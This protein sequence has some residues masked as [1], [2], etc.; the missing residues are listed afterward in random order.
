MQL[1]GRQWE[2]AGV[3]RFLNSVLN[4]RLIHQREHLFRLRF[5]GGKKASPEASGGKDRL[6]NL[7]YHR[8]SILPG[9]AP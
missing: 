1:V 6:T 3:D 9:S 4:Q 8:Y 7:G 5:G 2:K